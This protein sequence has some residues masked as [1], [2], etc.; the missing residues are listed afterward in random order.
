M[1]KILA[2]VLAGGKGKRMGILCQDRSK[3][4]LPFGPG[5]KVIDFTLSNCVNSSIDQISV[6]VD[7]Q[8]KSTAEYVTTWSSA[9]SRYGEIQI[10]EPANGGYKGTADA[11]YQHIDYIQRSAPDEVL[12]LAGDHVYQAD[13]RD[14]LDYHDYYK[15]DVTMCTRPVPIEQASRFG[16]VKI[17]NHNRIVDFVEKPPQPPGNLVSMGI[18]LFKTQALLECLERDHL[19]NSS[20]NDFGHDIIPGIIKKHRVMSYTYDGYWHDVGTIDSYFAAN[21]DYLNNRLS[22][23]A[24]KW[25]LQTCG[26]DYS[27][28]RSSTDG[29]I[30]NSVVS[31]NSSIEGRVINSIVF[32]HVRIGKNAIVSN[33][34]VLSNAEIGD[35]SM[36]DHCVLD[37]DVV[38]DRVCHIGK[39][40]IPAGRNYIT[41]LGKGARVSQ[42]DAISLNYEKSRYFDIPYNTNF[43]PLAHDLI[44]A[45]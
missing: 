11:V 30:S 44:L 42:Y 37:E 40:G 9:H 19:C 2:I 6:A 18:Y 13:Y 5:C 32:D 20:S 39:A 12:I 16:V 23:D 29:K 21:M 41:V 8:K 22:L 28:M 33:S 15:A 10:L 31:S 34:M 14:V 17:N 24:V 43:R 36:V 26:S 7:Y 1:K 4:V 25:P 45:R 38:I 3:P 27:Q 35:Y